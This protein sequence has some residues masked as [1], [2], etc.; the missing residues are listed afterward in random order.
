MRKRVVLSGPQE[1][2]KSQIPLVIEVNN[3][4]A[5]MRSVSQDRSNR[6]S[7]RRSDHP[8]CVLKFWREPSDP[9]GNLT[10]PD[11]PVPTEVSFRL[12]NKKSKVWLP[13]DSLTLAQKINLKFGG[14]TPFV[15]NKG[16]KLVTYADWN[17]GYQAQVLCSTQ[18][19]GQRIVEQLLDIQ[20]HFPN[21]DYAS[22]STNLNEA[23]RYAPP[24]GKESWH[25]EL[26]DEW[27]ER[28]QVEVRFK[29]A[30]LNLGRR[31]LVQLVDL[32]GKQPV[33]I[34]NL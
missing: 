4:L 30:Y 21:W 8:L 33:P 10:N 20:G 5:E 9:P 6:Q 7:V 2:L 24:T 22:I 19:E 14:N 13:A 3:L 34:L 18:T 29:H 26:I 27:H 11:D 15:W 17:L 28:P 31:K 25:G 1:V 23:S 12:M 16:V 32:T